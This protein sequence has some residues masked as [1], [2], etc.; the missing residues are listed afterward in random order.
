MGTRRQ[1]EEA[2]REEHHIIATHLLPDT[3]HL[4]GVLRHGRQQTGPTLKYVNTP[5][6]GLVPYLRRWGLFGEKRKPPRG[7][8]KFSCVQFR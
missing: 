6:A 7:R 8:P 1:A 4:G 5:V 2:A 3:P